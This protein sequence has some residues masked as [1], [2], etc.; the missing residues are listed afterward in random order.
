MSNVK[1]YLGDCL[2]VMRSLS[3]DSADLAF[4]DPPFNVGKGYDGYDDD[5]PRSE[6][7]AWCKDW[8]RELYRL[9]RPGGSF[10]VMNLERNAA[11]H[12]IDLEELGA[13][14]QNMIIWRDTQWVSPKTRYSKA[15]QD[16]VFCTK[17]GSPHTFNC[18]AD[19]MPHDRFWGGKEKHKH[20]D[21]ARLTY[22]WQDI[23]RI[24]GNFSEAIRGE[25]GKAHP[26]QMPLKLAK[27]IF[28]VS[29]NP[30]DTVLELFAGSATM[31][32]ECVR[33]DRNYIGIEKA[34]RYY[35]LAQERIQMA[36]AQLSM[37]LQFR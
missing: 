15:H 27:R 9:V 23:S 37:E 7:L 30:G 25:N 31:G 6:Y 21:G 18:F 3:D 32:E 10:Y 34:E 1:L 20:Q 19:T 33:L 36:Q 2:E 4:A 12:L 8:I 14:F 17:P 24:K 5:M 28:L 16:I 29:T 11:H 22:I 35:Q 13:E 26:C